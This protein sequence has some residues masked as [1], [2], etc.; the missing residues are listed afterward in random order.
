MLVTFIGT[1]PGD[2]GLLAIRAQQALAGAQVVVADTDVKAA[3]L[4]GA[5]EAAER[6]RVAGGGG[7][8]RGTVSALLR[9][10]A[11]A[12]RRVVRLVAGEGE[13]FQ[14]E[15]GILEAWGVGFDVV[16]GVAPSAAETWLARR[17]L[18]GRR[19]LVTRPRAQAGRLAALLEARGAEVIALPTIQI[20]PPEDWAPL[21]RAI[22]ELETF[23]WVVFTSVNGVAA[24]RERLGHAG[25][26]ARRL[27]GR[28]VAAIGP[29]TADAL[30]RGGIEP[31]LLPAEYRAEGLVEALRSRAGHGDAVLLV[32]AAEAREVLP[33]ELEARG[34][35]VTVAPAYRT[36]L[37][38]EGADRVRTLLESRGIDVVTFTSSSTVR[39]FL[40]VLAPADPR[41]LLEEVV[42]AAI[43]PITAETAA[44][45][46]LRVSVMP[47]AYTVPAL[48]DAI[49]GHFETVPPATVRG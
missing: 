2:P 17:P 15:A 5:P 23:Q 4:D 9:A 35:R 48:A 44:E 1:G 12:G 47:T 11:A 3:V 29:E 16:P 20:G 31:D 41:R 32:R 22:R 46:G 30:R 42:V 38:R 34:V 40:E 49:V 6:V 27:G 21:D 18:H 25:L 28:S 19:V 39:G 45:H 37:A 43:G 10:H 13:T 33:R 14:A 36:T 8:S 24:F 26:D 7:T